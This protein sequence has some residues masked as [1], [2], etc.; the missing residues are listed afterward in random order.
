[1]PE[2]SYPDLHTGL[3][4]AVTNDTHR[5]G[6]PRANLRNRLHPRLPWRWP[7]PQHRKGCILVVHRDRDLLATR[8]VFTTSRWATLD[9]ERG[10]LPSLS[11]NAWR[12]PHTSARRRLVALGVPPSS[13]HSGRSGTWSPAAL[14]LA[15]HASNS[16]A[17]GTHLPGDSS[18]EDERGGDP[19]RRE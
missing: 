1:M 3:A 18:S 17:P 10:D 14:G 8:F 9:E 15:N 19:S 6:R 13:S 11:R 4:A 2:P 16:V 7:S 5:G 12:L